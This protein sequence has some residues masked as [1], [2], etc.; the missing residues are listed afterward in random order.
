MNTKDGNYKQG[1]GK[2]PFYVV[3]CFCGRVGGDAEKL[4]C[5]AFKDVHGKFEFSYSPLDVSKFRG[6]L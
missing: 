1:H 4:V 3:C 6:C 2:E 5:D